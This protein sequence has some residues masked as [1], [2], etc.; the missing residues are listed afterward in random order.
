M[1]FVPHIPFV[2]QMSRR[3]HTSS[4]ASE[5]NVFVAMVG[6]FRHLV[7]KCL[8]FPVT[9]LRGSRVAKVILFA[10]RVGERM[11]KEK[12]ERERGK[13]IAKELASTCATLR[14]SNF[15]M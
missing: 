9:L 11:R 1:T 8:Y 10:T 5:F 14:G 4:I 6:S 13:R 2:P 7:N 12:G 3:D 15:F